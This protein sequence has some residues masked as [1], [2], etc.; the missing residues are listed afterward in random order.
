MR[1]PMK[2]REYQEGGGAQAPLPTPVSDFEVE[3]EPETEATQKETMPAKPEVS[4][5]HIAAEVEKAVA[6]IAA[7]KPIPPYLAK[8]V[9]VPLRKK[10]EADLAKA[11]ADADA[12]LNKALPSEE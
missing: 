10:L 11:L 3:V 4:E 12:K 6:L 9:A 8:I 2:R 7:G 5:G 1:R